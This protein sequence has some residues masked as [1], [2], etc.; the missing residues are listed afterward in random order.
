MLSG[1]RVPRPQT[2]H[3]ASWCA[4]RT[5][6][7]GRI[8][9]QQPAVRIHNFIRAQSRPYPGAFTSLDGNALHIWSSRRHDATYMGTPGQVAHVAADGVL[10]IAGDHR[11]IR[12]TEV[13]APGE[14][15]RPAHE[16][17]NSVKI[18]LGA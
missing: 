15:P 11:A 10:V 13:Q 3:G 9:W 14:P 17:L 16:V 8:D 7:D 4:A 1:E 5:P 2:S 18:R 12:V 6:D